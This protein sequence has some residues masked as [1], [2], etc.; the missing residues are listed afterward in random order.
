L[1]IFLR[2]TID[3]LSR[4]PKVSTPFDDVQP[5]SRALVRLDL[6]LWCLRS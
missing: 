1:R 2:L 4:L 5:A 3:L 6:G